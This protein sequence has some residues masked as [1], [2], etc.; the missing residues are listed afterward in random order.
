M[1]GRRSPAMKTEEGT[2]SPQRTKSN[3]ARGRCCCAGRTR[4]MPQLRQQASIAKDD[5]PMEVDIQESFGLSLSPMLAHHFLDLSDIAHRELSGIDQT[6][7][8]GFDLAV[9]KAQQFVDQTR[10]RLTA[11]NRGFE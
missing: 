4:V 1:S 2:S 3:T 10:S 9:E 11:G 5:S 8:H 7:H 6:R